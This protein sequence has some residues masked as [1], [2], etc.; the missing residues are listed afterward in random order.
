MQRRHFKQQSSSRKGAVVILLT[1]ILMVVLF[2][3]VAFA[4]DIGYIALVRTEL[5]RTADA[6]AHAA[7]Y[8]MTDPDVANPIQA[9][10]EMAQEVGGW[11]T[12]GGQTV[13][14]SDE[15][16]ADDIVFGWRTHDGT[17]WSYAWGTS[18]YNCV[19]VRAKRLSS[20]GNAV[21]LFFAPVFQMLGAD[22]RFQDVQAEAIA[23]INP[24]DI[25]FII[26]QSGSM[27]HDSEICWTRK[28]LNWRSGNPPD[29]EGDGDKIAKDLWDDLGLTEAGVPMPW[30][31]TLQSEDYRFDA[32]SRDNIAIELPQLNSRSLTQSRDLYRNVTGAGSSNIWTSDGKIYATLNY[33]DVNDIFSSSTIYNSFPSDF[34][35][36]NWKSSYGHTGDKADYIKNYD[37]VIE[38]Y[39]TEVMQYAKPPLTDTA[40]RD[41][42]RGYVGYARGYSSGT[43]SSSG[44]SGW[45]N[46]GS[47][48]YSSSFNSLYAKDNGSTYG[49]SNIESDFNYHKGKLSYETYIQFMMDHGYNTKIGRDDW[50]NGTKCCYSPMSM[51]WESD[52]GDAND[53]Y[54]RWD[55]ENNM[56]RPPRE[57]PASGVIDAVVAG[58]KAIKEQNENT[59][60]Q[61][62]DLVAVLI[63]HS[64][65]TPITG[66]S[67]G[68]PFTGDYDAAITAVLNSAGQSLPNG[69]SNMDKYDGSYVS[70][71]TN[72]MHGMY[73]A[74]DYLDPDSGYGRR[75]TNKV[76][77]FF[78]DGEA[79][80]YTSSLA[81]SISSAD[82]NTLVDIDYNDN[83]NIES[84]EKDLRYYYS[85]SSTDPKNSTLK[86]AHV[87]QDMD[88]VIHTI[89]AGVGRDQDIGYRLRALTGG[90]YYDS[91]G[92][93]SEYAANLIEA[94]KSAASQRS[95]SLALE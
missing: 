68:D 60:L 14:I 31:S 3:M 27:H 32:N 45:A 80:T 16:N 71:S 44:I 36:T 15:P 26:D 93:Y 59:P 47:G 49:S 38:Q 10:R 62:R 61:Y 41:Y 20:R 40:Y 24:R 4:V 46:P 51:R 34:N 42:W 33:S 19:K 81:R 94:F 75:F 84:N 79:N 9:A 87:A 30:D 50:G 6:A 23:A 5:Q 86:A 37:F 58:I 77:I 90:E 70:G 89:I 57:Q 91:G 69:S 21:P 65:I 85:Q 13:F 56:S 12:A 1:A 48:S 53:A 63:F 67:G 95:I 82:Y 22:S 78:T 73:E 28:L 29:G 55:S 92:A 18:S 54:R 11:H 88:V 7:A 35:G 64:K 83:G 2:G 52:G 17:K 39:L 8:E 72:T 43:G 25:V 74:A 76:G 66:V